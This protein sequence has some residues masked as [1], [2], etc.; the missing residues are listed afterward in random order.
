[1]HAAAVLAC[2]YSA[3]GSTIDVSFSWADV[4]RKTQPA[5]FDQKGPLDINMDEVVLQGLDGTLTLVKDRVDGLAAAR[6]KAVAAA[7]PPAPPKAPAEDHTRATAA[8]QT[9]AAT[10]TAQADGTTAT[11]PAGPGTAPTNQAPAP[12]LP[13]ASPA[14]PG[15][16]AAREPAHFILQAGGAAFIP[17]GPASNYFAIAGAPS[18]HAAYEL[19][20]PPGRLALGLIAAANVFSAVGP[21]ETAT[22]FLIPIGPDVRYSI[23]GD[24]PLSVFAHLSAGPAILV[25]STASTGAQAGLTAYVKSG[26]GA[27]FMFGPR[28][29][30]ELA[31]D[32]EVYFELP[33][34]IMG[35]STTL[36][37]TVKL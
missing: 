36:Q 4:D 14:A 37:A 6:A 19:P 17:V 31:A 11:T 33:Y 3:S 7:A 29:G 22:G 27:G 26:L 35:L 34:L 18:L 32:Y 23:G 20:V 15:T 24:T 30:L 10:S 13:P 21:T 9:G 1:M 5:T 8:G 25:L 2:R 12:A 16:S 28:F